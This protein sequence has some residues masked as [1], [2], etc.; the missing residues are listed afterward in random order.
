MRSGDRAGERG[1]GLAAPGEAASGGTGAEARL[2]LRVADSDDLAVL[3]SVLQDAV[4]A[5]G[6]M[7]YVA[8]EKLFIMLASRFRWEAALDDEAEDAAHDVYER[9]HCGVAFEAVEGVKVRGID[10]KDR[11][12]YLDLLTLRAEE[13][14]VVLTFAGGAAIRL[15]A[16]RISCHMRDMGEPWPTPNRP[17]H[18]APEG[19]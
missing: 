13:E 4:V 6:D 9:I 1:D 8:S 7:R 2:A 11:S 3:A 16:P 18:Q 12:Q 19:A 15:D 10:L 14:G 17:E 5:I